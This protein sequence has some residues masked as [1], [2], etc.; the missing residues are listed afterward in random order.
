MQT[1][2]TLAN[3]TEKGLHDIKDT[4]KRVDAFKTAAADRGARVKE[5]VW[6]QGAYDMVAIIE[7]PDDTTMS[8]LMLSAL[9]LGNVSG[10]TLRAFTAA[11]MQTILDRVS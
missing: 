11:E 4:V 5:I 3:F 2:V 8:A 1:Y 9:K 10:Q 7:A 6:T